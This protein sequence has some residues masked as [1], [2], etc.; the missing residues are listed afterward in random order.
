M[1][2]AEAQ[3]KKKKRKTPK[4]KDS[5]QSDFNHQPREDAEDEEQARSIH[6]LQEGRGTLGLFPDEVPH[7]AVLSFLKGG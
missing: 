6:H 1:L 4:K 3:K 2:P 7:G 5:Q